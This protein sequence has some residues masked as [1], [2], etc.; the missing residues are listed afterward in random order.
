MSVEDYRGYPDEITVREVKVGKKVLVTTLLNPRQTPKSELRQ[1]FWQRWNVEL[2]LRN[3][4][5]TLGMERFSCKTP[6][7]V[8]KELWVYLLAYNLIRLLMAEAASQ[9]GALPRQLSFKHT[10]QIWVAWSAR[11]FLS[12][13]PRTQSACLCSSRRYASAIDLAGSSRG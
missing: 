13:H 12:R 3:I 5:S 8:E 11:Q 2:D 1:L 9:A 4:K 10:L 6:S 7:M